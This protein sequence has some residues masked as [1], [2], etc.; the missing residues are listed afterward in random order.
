MFIF[1]DLPYLR[2]ICCCIC[3]LCL[4]TGFAG[5][6]VNLSQAISIRSKFSPPGKERV[7]DSSANQEMYNNN[8]K[9]TLFIIG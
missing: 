7:L 1:L 5:V 2:S 8:T 4:I 3:F 9:Y 6:L